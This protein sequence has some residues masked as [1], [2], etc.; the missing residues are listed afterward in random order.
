MNRSSTNC[1]LAGAL[2]AAA[3]AAPATPGAVPSPPPLPAAVSWTA[4]IASL[5]EVEGAVRTWATAWSNRDV[6][7]Y[8]SAY[9]P[10]FSP[11]RGQDRRA[12]EAERRARIG[13]K[14]SISVGIEDLVISILGQ[15]ASASFRQVYRADAFSETGRKTLELQRVDGRWLITKENNGG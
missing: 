11:P 6:E 10:D 9:S 13:E 7:R 12:W 2:L 4:S 15:A 3:T 1:L 14:S 8:F 5:A